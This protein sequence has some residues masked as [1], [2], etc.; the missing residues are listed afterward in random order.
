MDARKQIWTRRSRHKNN[1]GTYY[2]AQIADYA[3]FVGKKELAATILRTVGTNRIAL[4]VEPDGREPLEL[5]R[6]RA[7]SYSIGNLAG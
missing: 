1:H 5:K 2:D 7:W 4:Q 3:F 6:T